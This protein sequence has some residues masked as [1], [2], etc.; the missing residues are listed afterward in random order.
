MYI[1]CPNC[2]TKFAVLPEQIGVLGRKVKC[3]K[4]SHIWHQKPHGEIRLEP[5][6]S[7]SSKN[8]VNTDYI[9]GKG[10]VNLP[11][12]LPINIPA[13]LYGLPVLLIAAIIFVTIILF[14]DNQDYKKLGIV[15]LKVNNDLQAGRIVLSYKILNNA[16]YQVATPLIR[17]RLLGE[18]NRVLKFHIVDHT[19]VLLASKQYLNIK[20]EFVSP[21]SMMQRIDITLGNKLDFLLKW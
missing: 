19:D 16:D 6:F 21:P 5:I 17:I 4:C 7:F 8:Q 13:Y 11:A 3:S 12:L 15:D 10:G 1:S 14:Q 20:T 2:D 18:D 9:V